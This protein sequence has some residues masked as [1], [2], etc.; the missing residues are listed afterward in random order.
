MELR[1]Q[2][3]ARHILRPISKIDMK[4]CDN[5]RF[6]FPLLHDV[7]SR[8]PSRRVFSRSFMT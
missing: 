3:E 4:M 5:F 8:S 6:L 1:L 7:H 2:R